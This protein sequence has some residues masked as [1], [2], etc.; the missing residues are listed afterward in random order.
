MGEPAER[1]VEYPD[2]DGGRAGGITSTHYSVP[3]SL[4]SRIDYVAAIQ[5]AADIPTILRLVLPICNKKKTTV[6]TDRR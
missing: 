6:Q 2:H 4:S 1:A 3:S 5:Y